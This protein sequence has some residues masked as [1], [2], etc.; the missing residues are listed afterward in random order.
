[1]SSDSTEQMD[2]ILGIGAPLVD[3]L[4]SAEDSLLDELGA[5]KGGMSLV[6]QEEI[7]RLRSRLPL[8]KQSAGGSA[9][10]TV[11]AIGALG[12]PAAMYGK[13]GNDDL[14]HFFLQDMNRHGV[15]TSR[16]EHATQESTG[17]VCC[18]ITPDGERTFRTYLGAAGTLSPAECSGLNLEGIG[19]IHMEGY[20]FFQSGIIDAICE[21]AN[22]HSTQIKKSLDLASFDVVQL[23]R[24]DL[25]ELLEREIDIVFA[26]E[27]EGAAVSGSNDP[28][29]MLKFLNRYA[30][31]AVVKV[32]ADGAYA[33]R[34][35]EEPVF[36]PGTRVEVRDTTG[37]GDFWA[38]GF[39]CGLLQNSSLEHAVDLGNLLGSTIVQHDGAQLSPETWNE[40]KQQ[41]H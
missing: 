4:L 41:I 24:N 2:T 14:G 8:R 32:G 27:Q 34:R 37:A 28:L 23:F 35:G 18:L 26:N 6:P 22:R 36:R 3:I 30:E 20:L 10:N 40:L 39:F 17:C 21:T 19:I 5:E 11:K 38:A 25:L 16:V 9:A 12:Y 33:C 7:D 1:M 31:L 13:V 15:D 29:E